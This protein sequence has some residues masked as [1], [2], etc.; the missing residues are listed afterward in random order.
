M[1]TK[2]KEK[3]PGR[4]TIACNVCRSRKQKK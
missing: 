3:R 1:A 2:S 4:I